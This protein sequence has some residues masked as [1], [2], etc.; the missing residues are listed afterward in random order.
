MAKKQKDTDYL[1]LSAYLRA[2]ESKL[3]S[4]ERI[5][6]ML[7]AVDAEDAGKILEECGYSVESELTLSRLEQTL[8]ERRREVFAELL[9]LAPAPE[10]INA[11]IIKYDYHNIKVLLKAEGAGVDGGLLFSPSGRVS[12]AALSEAYKSE[13]YSELPP[14]LAAAIMA[15]KN[16]LSETGDPQLSDFY[17]DRVYFEE[18][19]QLTKGAGSRFLSGYVRLLID[20]ANLRSAVR[21]ARMGKDFAFLEKVQIP[22]GDAPAASVSAAALGGENLAPF[23]SDSPLLS[24]AEEGTKCLSGGSLTIF[25]QLCDN[26]LISYIS[27]AK[28]V[29]FGEQ[30]LVAYICA[31]EAEIMAVRIIMTGRLSKLDPTL[32][33][34]RLR[35]LYV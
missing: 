18:L 26:A 6:R 3:L 32:I 27:R 23:F 4:S 17:V 28:S 22:G 25:E 19:S 35:D 31:I 34:E 9:Y 16:V 5:G 1:F 21:C 15:G 8:S 12:A 30:P 2:K 29:S 13:D 7:D 24:A 14:K 33:R 20:S 11:F 10:I